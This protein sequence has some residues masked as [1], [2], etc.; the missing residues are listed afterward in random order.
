MTLE[1]KSRTLSQEDVDQVQ[2]LYEE[3]CT[4]L[5]MLP[6]HGRVECA[7][8]CPSSLEWRLYAAAYALPLKH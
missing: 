7:P 8:F 4:L 3:Q 6:K 5:M 1:A 2:A